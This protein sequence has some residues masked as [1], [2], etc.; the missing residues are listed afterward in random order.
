MRERFILQPPAERIFPGDDRKVLNKSQHPK[1]LNV[2][3]DCDRWIAV[4][5]F[6]ERRSGYVRPDTDGLH[7]KASSKTGVFEALTQ[8]V[9][10][11]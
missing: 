7:G 9:H 10:F 2:M 11:P 5:D 1:Y 6:V 4:F 8:S 3:S